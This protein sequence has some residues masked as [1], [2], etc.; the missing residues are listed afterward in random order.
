MVAIS[1]FH[2]NMVSNNVGAD[3]VLESE[4]LNAKSAM[5]KANYLRIKLSKLTGKE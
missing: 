2:I 3:F 5:E 4:G 1:Y